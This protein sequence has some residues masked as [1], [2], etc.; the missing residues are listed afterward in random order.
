MCETSI[1]QD[2]VIEAGNLPQDKFST[3]F[4]VSPATECFEVSY[5]TTG[6]NS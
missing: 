1:T 6:I 5:Y 3:L 2:K 4:P